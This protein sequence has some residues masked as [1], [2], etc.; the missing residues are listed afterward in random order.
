MTE[1]ATKLE[2]VTFFEDRAEVTRLVAVDL[3]PGTHDLILTGV[4][5]LVHDASLQVEMHGDNALRVVSSRVVRRLVPPSQA[6]A[7]IESL[8]AEQRRA[9]REAAAIGHAQQRTQE[10]VARTLSLLDHWREGLAAS[11]PLE[12]GADS[13]WSRSF[14]RLLDAAQ[15]GERDQVVA[16]RAKRDADVAAQHA[17][18]RLAEARDAEPQ[19]VCEVHVQVVADAPASG[20][21]QVLYR[22]PGAVWRPEHLLRLTESGD[23]QN[24][25]I[26]TWATAWQI[27][28]E[29][30]SGIQPRFSTARPAS[31]ASAP[32]PRDDVLRSRRKTPEERS[33]VAVQARDVAM[34]AAREGPRASEMPGVDDGGKPREYQALEATPL[35]STGEPQRI[36]V[37]SRSLA[38]EV[39]RVAFPER[40]PLAHYA[41]RGVMGTSPLL[42]GPARIARGR[43][44][45]GRSRVDFVAGGDPFE[46]GLG[47]DEGI[48]LRRRIKREHDRSAVLGRQ[49]VT[50]KVLVFL[51]NLSDETR[52]V[53]VV[54]RIPVSEIE[55]VKVR[56]TRSPGWDHD[57]RDGMLTATVNLPP[58]AT[59]ELE[60][61]YELKAASDVTLPF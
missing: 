54:E 10:R 52:T 2:A 21:I 19:L 47:P 55:D 37:E 6:G 14:D 15:E 43:G 7:E 25:E 23:G 20:Q 18:Q 49:T 9:R 24:L 1:H 56:L 28:G 46:L 30:W 26:T 16:G 60:I 11:P 13:P 29:D 51:S 12:P 3:Q 44:Q 40:V 48:R 5:A 38:V 4:T 53:E 33:Q 31:A 42:A 57:E 17:S 8:E 39:R 35:P 41:V 22:T 50:T 27:T 36:E 59:R 45:V 58:R 61:E 32:E 34:D